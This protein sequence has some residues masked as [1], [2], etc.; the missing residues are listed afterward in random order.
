[1]MEAFKFFDKDGSGMISKDELF[2][3]GGAADG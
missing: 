1:M 3:S 2:V